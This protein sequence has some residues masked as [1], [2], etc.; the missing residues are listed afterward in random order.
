MSETFNW[1]KVSLGS[2][3]Y[4]PSSSSS[5]NTSE[6]CSICQSSIDS[7]SDSSAEEDILLKRL[8]ERVKLFQRKGSR[9][10]KKMG[11]YCFWIIFSNPS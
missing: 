2:V 4:H 3:N 7:S 8:K 9:K 10:L 6:I 5:S 11:K 1:S